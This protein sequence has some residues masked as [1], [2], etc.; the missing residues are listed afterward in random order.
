MNEHRH[1]FSR[2]PFDYIAGGVV[3][4][5]EKWLEKENLFLV[6]NWAKDGLTDEQIAK[7]IGISTSTLYEWKKKYSEFSEALKKGK[8]I[9]DYQVQ[10]ML[11]QKALG[12]KKTVKKAFKVKDIKYRDGKRISEKENIVYAEEEI[13]IPPDT[14][15]Q[16][17]WLKKRRPDVWGDKPA[18]EEKAEDTQINIVVSPIGLDKEANNE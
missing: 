13:Y 8:E 3:A 9:I 14:T 17:F 18:F 15:A 16:I 11:L 4:K 7:K 12:M 1:L 6:S 5:Y 10:N 2:V